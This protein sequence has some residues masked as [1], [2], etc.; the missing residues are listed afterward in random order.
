LFSF[1]GPS[2]VADRNTVEYN[3]RIGS[4]QCRGPQYSG[5]RIPRANF[6]SPII[7]C[8]IPHQ[9]HHGITSL[10]ESSAQTLTDESGSAAYNYPFAH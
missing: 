10:N 5:V 7:A 4:L 2:L 9:P 6:V 1:G 3:D 8:L